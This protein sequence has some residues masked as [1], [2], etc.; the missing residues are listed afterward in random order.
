MEYQHGRWMLLI[1]T[2]VA[3]GIKQENAGYTLPVILTIIC[4]GPIRK[5][6]WQIATIIFMGITP[7][8]FWLG[9]LKALDFEGDLATSGLMKRL[10][11][12]IISFDSYEWHRIGVLISE[13]GRAHLLLPL[14]VG[15]LTFSFAAFFIQAENRKVLYF[16]L[17]TWL[18]S[19]V[20]VIVTYG[21]GNPV[22]EIRWWLLT[23]FGRILSTWILIT[24]L[25][26][27]LSSMVVIDRVIGSGKIQPLPLSENLTTESTD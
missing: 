16:I 24:G 17:I 12:N 6:S 19:L 4:I 13:Y 11:G 23:S 5:K 21:F 3:I 10:Y 27:L 25:L 8:L 14:I 22:Y 1:F 9:V 15:L 18:S 7:L 26:V 2:I 20:V